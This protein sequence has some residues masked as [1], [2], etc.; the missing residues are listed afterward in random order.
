MLSNL[1]D[2][3]EKG[4]KLY[5]SKSK[6][7]L[8]LLIL[9]FIV[10][11]FAIHILI[12]ISAEGQIKNVSEIILSN[13]ILPIIIFTIILIIL[14]AYIKYIILLIMR[15]TLENKQITV[16]EASK[17]AM[18]VA[19]QALIVVT[20]IKTF[21]LVG[22]LMLIVPGIIIFTLFFFAEYY[23][24]FE[25]SSMIES[26][27]RSYHLVKDRFLAVAWRLLGSIII[28]TVFSSLI[29]Q[30]F[31]FLI[32]GSPVAHIFASGQISTTYALNIIVAATGTLFFPWIAATT[33][34]LFGELQ[35]APGK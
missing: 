11:L 13:Y 10:N 14:G 1:I 3:I 27:E 29:N 24:L 33:L 15:A 32:V 23:I 8:P 25:K 19:V 20:I 9:I 5:T 7:I 22:A 17:S 31:K 26:F 28:L 21:T 18:L 35:K 12:L 4:Y 30:V 2:L 34:V 6:M 16:V